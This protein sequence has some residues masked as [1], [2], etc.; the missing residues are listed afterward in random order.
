MRTK[1]VNT[2]EQVRTHPRN[3]AGL[4]WSLVAMLVAVL[5]A[6]CLLLW[7]PTNVRGKTTEKVDKSPEGKPYA[8]GELLVT[9][10]QEAPKRVEKEMP[11]EVSGKVEEEIE[12]LDS[13]LLI[14]P[15][16][17][18]QGSKENRV[19]ALE[20]KKAVLEEEPGVASVE[21]N[22]VRKASYIPNDSRFSRQY[23]LEKA[24]FPR[25]WN[26]VRGRGARIAIVD[27]GIDARHPDLADKIVL[28]KDFVNDDAVADDSP[29]GHGTH[30]AGIAAASTNNGKGIAGGCP[31][32]KLVIAKATQDLSGTISDIAE[33]IVWSADNGAE[34]INLSLSG[35]EASEVE[36]KAVNYA[37][38]KG[39][40]VVGA[41]G[42]WGTNEPLYPAAYPNSV[43]VVATD[44]SDKVAGFS[45]YGRSVDVAAPGV[46]L[47]STLPDG[48]YG[49]LSGTSMAAPYVSA[50]AGLLTGKG[51]DQSEVRRRIEN[52]ALDL[53]KKGKDPR[54]GHGRID[55]LA[56]VKGTK[57]PP[58]QDIYPEKPKPKPKRC[59]I[60]GT[61]GNDI[62]R[63]TKGNDVICALSGNDI[64]RGGGGRD[65]IRGG[66]GNDLLK[67]GRDNDLISGGGGRD[68][69]EDE[70]GRDHLRGGSG[71]DLLR[72]R[73]RR[74]G[75]IV[76]GGSG[77]DLCAADSG[78]TIRS[79]P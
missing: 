51:F 4:S 68:T 25:A 56:A 71:T 15:E 12:K 62:L 18:K 6:L 73:D 34:V 58:V 33:A 1:R 38:R 35:P 39:A 54:Y 14:F 13:Q 53:G 61:R 9:Y 26:K 48:K 59:T 77:R 20:Q 57:P 65:V 22:Y 45:N 21:Y 64:V 2:L 3:W 31:N 11:E 8:A 74:A 19:N 79:C 42:N 78:D 29:Y 40:V 32:C 23:A 55:A 44:R 49:Y 24:S 52:G 46:G 67:G 41:A 28:Q 70:T 76:D 69:L 7:F 63:G 5:A 16:V 30:V 66:S 43:S 47:L 37:T 10:E 72:V 27:D 36:R 50:L 75:D 17:K 60:T